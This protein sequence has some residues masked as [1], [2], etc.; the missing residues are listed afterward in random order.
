MPSETAKPLRKP[1]EIEVLVIGLT[2]EADAWIRS[3]LEGIAHRIVHVGSPEEGF[4]RGDPDLALVEEDTRSGFPDRLGAFKE[5]HPRCQIL[6]IGH[7]DSELSPRQLGPAMVRHWFFRPIDPEEI[8]RTF[9]LAGRSIARVWRERERHTRSLTALD[10]FI[11]KSPLLV[12]TLDMTRKAAASSSTSVLILGET[13]TGKNLLARAIH[14]ES[15]RSGGPFVDI[16]CAALP[17]NLLESE[18]FGHD[19]G[20]FTSAYRD[21]PGMLEL[22][23]GGTAFLDE[24]G[25][26]DPALQVKLLKFLDDGVIRRVQ[27]TST[28]H[29]DVRVIAATNRNLESEVRDGRFRLDLFH[30][31]GVMVLRLPALRERKE[32]IPLLANH[33][34]LELS[35]RLRGRPLT[36]NPQ[37]LEALAGYAWPGN[38]RELINVTERLVLLSDGERALGPEDL[39]AGMAPQAPILCV[40]SDGETPTVVLPADGLS[41]EAIERAI[42]EDALRQ[43]GGNVTRAAAF[44]R[45]G[46]G[47]LRYRLERLDLESR[48]S[49]RRGRPM[50]RR[51]PRAA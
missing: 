32:D 23:D 28:L 39:P 27:A 41:F 42:L 13:G 34:L 33:Y 31:L 16:N 21:K 17:A 49:G 30:R 38:V 46:R 43:T 11:G 25:E 51:R 3:G 9:Q 2:G 19:K 48:A 14:G 50:G 37:A 15:P 35:R 22:A 40:Q 7:E 47:S 26:L 12:E 20:A 6:L 18:L 4:G 10:A 24:I 45:M 8:I 29:V 5:A 1:E 36:W 44:L